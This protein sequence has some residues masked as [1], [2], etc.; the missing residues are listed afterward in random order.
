M[1]DGERSVGC[2]SLECG[3]YEHMS[4]LQRRELQNEQVLLGMRD[5]AET[6]VRGD[7]H[8]RIHR[9]KNEWRW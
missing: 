3:D 9:R 7:G 1:Y 4:V 8:A 6:W 5:C 2:V